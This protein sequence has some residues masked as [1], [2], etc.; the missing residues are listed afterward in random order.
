MNIRA[1][2]GVETGLSMA[3]VSSSHY[4]AFVVPREE[5]AQSS[6]LITYDEMRWLET[7]GAETLIYPMERN[8]YPSMAGRAI[9]RDPPYTYLAWVLARDWEVDSS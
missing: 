1:L 2:S 5:A 9:F 7:D 6:E 8:R 3:F 4:V